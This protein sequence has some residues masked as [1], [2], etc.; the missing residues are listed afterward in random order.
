[1]RVQRVVCAGTKTSVRLI[2]EDGLPVAV[3]AEFLAHLDA[4]DCSPNTVRAY[5]YDL[6][7]FWRFLQEQGWGWQDFTAP[8]ALA[9][10]G[11]LRAVVS[12][13]P[14]Q[15]LGLSVAASVE[16]R[17]A[18]RLSPASVNRAL[19]AVSSFYEFVIL[20]GREGA[21]GN[22]IE[23]RPDPALARVSERRRPALGSSS[24]QQPVRRSVRVKTV[25][26]LPRPLSVEQVEALL[27]AVRSLRD[28]ALLLLMLE[29]G[30]R[31]GEALGL[32]LD[33]IAYGRRRVVVR[34]R[35]DHPA[36]VRSKSRIE[37][38]VDLHE[39]PALAALSAY[40][41]GKRPAETESPLVF[42]IEAGRRRGQPLAYE[43]LARLFAR[44]AQRAG[45]RQVW[46]TPHTLRHTHATRMWEGGMRELA[47]QRRL[48]HASPDSTR[49]Y[50]RVS[51][52]V[53]LAEYRRALGGSE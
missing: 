21:G 36:G 44:A 1:M 15:R 12:A 49:R 26:R 10:L 13:A 32:W 11:Y 7:H 31:P 2:D 37:R 38:V 46:V 22:P 51:D 47:L 30:L 39:G 5:A 28:R 45:I 42:L 8:R 19:A 52:P 6:L 23:R 18:R 33:D 17:A 4:R 3:V 25:E 53:V 41:M 29:G 20:S 40:V 43:G 24:R 14:A 50:T 9:L 27:A 35:D 16:G 34:H 48:G